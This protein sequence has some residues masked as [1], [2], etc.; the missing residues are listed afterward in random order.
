MPAVLI[1]QRLVCLAPILHRFQN[2]FKTLTELR[3]GIF[4]TRRH[5]RKNLAVHKPVRLHIPKLCGQHLL[6]Y[7]ADRLFQFSKTLGSRQ[8]IPQDQH[9]PL[10]ADKRQGRLHRAAERYADFLRTRGGQH[11]LLLELG[12]GY[13]TPVIIKFPFWQMT[14]QNPKAVYACINTGDAVCP[15]DI[16]KQAICIDADIVEVLRKL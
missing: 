13:N 8:K 1:L 16:E 9:L 15:R 4:H 6:A 10:V 2:R 7:A 14:K 12:V 11:I 5:F 3:Q